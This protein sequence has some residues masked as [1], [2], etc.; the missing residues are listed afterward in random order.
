MTVTALSGEASAAWQKVREFDLSKTDGGRTVPMTMAISTQ[1]RKLA[2]ISIHCPPGRPAGA[3]GKSILQVFDTKSGDLIW[4]AECA[5][6]WLVPLFPRFAADDTVLVVEGADWKQSRENRKTVC[7][8]AETGAVAAFDLN[9]LPA[10]VEPFR[11]HN[12]FGTEILSRDKSRKVVWKYD[13]DFQ[14][15]ELLEMPSGKTLRGLP[16][17]NVQGIRSLHGVT[18]SANSLR[19]ATAA[20]DETVRIF[21]A[22][23]GHQLAVLRTGKMRNQFTLFSEGGDELF[24]LY[25]NGV[26]QWHRSRLE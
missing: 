3:D 18:F 16:M 23:D 10:P 11:R 20:Y 9:K 25:T 4:E 6:K 19:F 8:N 13:A 1:G 2:V 22:A 14:G 17:P 12:G 21:D 5:E 24:V 7:Y 15:A 26:Q